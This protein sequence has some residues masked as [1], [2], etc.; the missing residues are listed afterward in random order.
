V[1][2]ALTAS[3]LTPVALVVAVA[4][5]AIVAWRL[6][7][8]TAVAHPHPTPLTAA[9]F[10][11]AVIMWQAMM[12]AMMTP[13]V[14][15]WITAYARLVS[16]EGGSAS[17][18]ATVRFGGGYF[19]I[20]LVYSAGAALLQLALTWSGAIGH[21]PSSWLAGI[22]LVGA[23]AFQFTPLKTACLTHCRN[24]ISYLLAQ[25][26]GGPPGA[27]ALGLRHGA[28]CVGCCWMLMLTG[29]AMGLMNLAWMAVLTVVIAVEQ[30]APFGRHA[31]RAIGVGLVGW[32]LWMGVGL[33]LAARVFR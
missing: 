23:G 31:A 5:A 29:F 14:A 25:W 8:G 16:D 15:P 26:R 9:G 33:P 10:V 6:G 20:W 17:H 13:T 27:F 19:A 11:E 30:L 2:R 28:Y 4:G 1:G 24:P 21:R 3:R 12:V 18:W 22:V 7:A 32:G